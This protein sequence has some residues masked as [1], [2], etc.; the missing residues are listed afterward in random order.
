MLPHPNYPDPGLLQKARISAVS[1]SIAPEFFEPKVASRL[2]H[3]AARY[4]PMP[5]ATIHEDRHPL[6]TEVEVWA[7]R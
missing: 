5:E 2:W 3:M 6:T 4:T 1:R 7:T